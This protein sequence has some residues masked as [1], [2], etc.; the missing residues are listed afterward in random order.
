MAR[1]KVRLNIMAGGQRA[2]GWSSIDRFGPGLDYK[3]DVRDGLPF[4]DSEADMAVC[5]HGLDLLEAAD[6]DVVLTHVHRVLRPEAVLR[7]SLFDIRRAAEA[8]ERKDR[9]WFLAKGAPDVD[10][11]RQYRWMIYQNGARKWVTT[12]FLVG[13]ICEARGFVVYNV[14][15]DETVC[16]DPGICCFDSRAD[17]SFFLDA[18]KK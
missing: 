13:L 7:I 11:S 10:L 18:V 8:V 14:A 3:L 5:H 6:V 12:P 9:A 1:Y 15:Q 16:A 2:P 17:E 4:A